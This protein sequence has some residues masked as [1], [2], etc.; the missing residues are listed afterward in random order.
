M[1]T[2]VKPHS[3]CRYTQAPIDATLQLVKEHNVQP[4]EIEKIT[5]GMLETGIPVICEPAERKRQPLGIVDAQFS[6]PFGIAVALIKRRA[7][8]EEF[9]PPML[10]DPLVQE[11]MAKVGYTRDPEL[12]KNY[13]REWPAWARAKLT[14]GREVF[15]HVRFPKGDPENPLSWDELIEK[16]RGLT[17]AV[18]SANKVSQVQTAVQ[19]IEQTTHIT[20]FTRLL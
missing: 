19:A 18:W 17:G 14:D 2:A 5:I 12:E 13:P 6:L 8:L 11:V 10:T 15:A 3:C 4:G 1:Q 16:Y 20:D 7:G 9:S